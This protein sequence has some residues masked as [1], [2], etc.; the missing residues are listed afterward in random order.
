MQAMF[1]KISALLI[2][3]LFSV[4]VFAQAQAPDQIVRQVTDDVFATLKAEKTAVQQDSNKLVEIVNR[5]I[6]PHTDVEETSK[7]VLAKHWRNLTPEQQKVFE[8][9]FEKLLIRTY[10]ISF[11]SYDKQ[12]IDILET[13]ANPNNP[14]M[15]EVRTLIKE[16]GKPGLPVNYRFMKETD[17]VWKVYDINVDNV[18]LVSSFRTQIGDAIT[19]EGF[20]AMLANMRAKNAEKF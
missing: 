17:G 19:R 14:N 12:V 10:A 7:R 18:S 6:I 8:K 15:V 13:R 20:D 16:P 4:Q 5:F 3:L 9:E 2:G 1:K 11:R